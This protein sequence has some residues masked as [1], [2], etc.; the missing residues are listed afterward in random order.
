MNYMKGRKSGMRK[1]QNWKV[2]EG[3][4]RNAGTDK[5]RRWEGMRG[6]RNVRKKNR[7]GKVE[8]RM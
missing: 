7:R 2:G 6:K 3:M 4:R 1:R 8:E 5:R